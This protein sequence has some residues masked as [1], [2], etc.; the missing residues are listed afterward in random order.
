MRRRVVVAV[1]VFYAAIVAVLV[2]G[3]QVL[4]K[5]STTTTTTCTGTLAH[6]AVDD[7]IV[8][9]GSVCRVNASTVDGS[10]TVGQDA[11]FEAAG[12]EIRGSVRATGATTVFLRDATS[13]RGSVVISGTQ[14]LFLYKTTVAG[15][16]KITDAVAAGFGHVQVCQTVAGQIEVRGSGPDV[17]IGDPAGGCPGNL[18]KQNVLVEANN[19]TSELEVSGNTIDGSLVVTNNTGGSP[20][21]VV[22]NT[23]I[24]IV[25]IAGNAQPFESA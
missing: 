25:D 13:V 12:T 7:L 19:T 5:R 3:P 18:V 16:V 23:V 20:K 10:V 2:F 14:Q 21:H 9:D 8:P 15:T 4:A 22:D 24:G 11:Y 17:L 1:V 6:A